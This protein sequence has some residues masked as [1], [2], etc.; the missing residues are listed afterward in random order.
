MVGHAP[1]M[2]KR[3]FGFNLREVETERQTEAERDQFSILF[4]F[5]H[6][7]NNLNMRE[8]ILLSPVVCLWKIYLNQ[9]LIVIGL[10]TETG[11]VSR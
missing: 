6:K 2:Y 1:S 11:D 3:E 4:R 8:F 5:C 9:N 10:R 7:I